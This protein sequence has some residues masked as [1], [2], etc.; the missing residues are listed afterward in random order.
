MRGRNVGLRREAH[1]MWVKSLTKDVM[2]QTVEKQPSKAQQSKSQTTAKPWCG[3]SKSGVDKERKQETGTLPQLI[4]DTVVLSSKMTF[5]DPFGSRRFSLV[6]C[7]SS[8]WLTQILG[9]T[10]FLCSGVSKDRL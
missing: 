1:E 3:V 5:S 8:E 10:M 9:A 4:S 2:E 7:L 6:L